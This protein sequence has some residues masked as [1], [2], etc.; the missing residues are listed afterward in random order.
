MRNSEE[1]SKLYRLV[2]AILTTYDDQSALKPRLAGLDRASAS[3]DNLL[4][5]IA[6]PARYSKHRKQREVPFAGLLAQ[7]NSPLTGPD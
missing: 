2:T 3:Y 5:A 7:Y 1:L 6:P 4:I